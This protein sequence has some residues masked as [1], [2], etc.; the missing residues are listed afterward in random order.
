M[1][2]PIDPELLVIAGRHHC[3]VT[4]EDGVRVGGAGSHLTAALAAAQAELGKTSPPTT[5][6]GTPKSFLAQAKP[7]VI[8]A[9]LGLDDIGIAA[10]SLGAWSRATAA[11]QS[12]A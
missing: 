2:S 10:A 1:V 7:D 11:R 6:L 3:V 12:Q 8:L 9:E 5:I 4:V